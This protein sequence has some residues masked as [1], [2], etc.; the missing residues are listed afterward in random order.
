Q[1]NE[2]LEERT[3]ELEK[4]KDDIKQKNQDLE[5]SKS[6]LKTK[7]DDLELTSKYKSEFLAN[8]SHELR[9]P[10]NSILILSKIL[11]DNKTGNFTDKQVELADTINAAG[12]DLLTLINDI[13]DLSKIEAGKM[14]LHVETV[15]LGDF[16]EDVNRKFKPATDEKGIAFK[17]D[18]AKELPVSILTDRQRLDQIIKNFLSNAIKFTEKGS[19]TLSICRPQTGLD[20]PSGNFESD[21]IVAISVIDTGIGIPKDKQSMIFEAFQQVDGTTS[22]K[23]GGT[24][25]GLSICRELVR[26]LGGKIE[27]Q[28]EMGKGSSFTVYLPEAFKEEQKT[29]DNNKLAVGNVQLANNE[30]VSESVAQSATSNEQP[31]TSNQFKPSDLESDLVW[32][33]RRN[34][35]LGDK[36][37]LVIEDDSKFAKII[38]ELAHEKGF[39]CLVAENGEIGLYMADYYKPSAIILDIGLPGIDGFSVMERLKS[40]PAT[41]HIPVNFLSGS[42]RSIDAMKMGAVGFLTKPATIEMLNGLFGKF[43]NIIAKK[44]KK[45][46]IVEDN[47]SMRKSIIELLGNGDITSTGVSTGEEAYELLKTG[48][49]DCMVLDL[50]LS[51]MSGS[52]LLD[53]I[54][55]NKAIS[56]IP[57]IIYTGKELP[58]REES[59]LKKYA[60][61][62]IIKG[63]KSPERLLDETALFLHRVEANLPIEKQRILRTIHNKDAVF[64][65]KKILLIDDDMRNVFALTH[66]IEEKGMEVVIGRNGRDGL[67]CLNK[68]PDVDLVL[69]D[70]MMPEMDGY[71]ATREI[72]KQVRFK[73]LP[74]IA[75][76]AKAMA[77]DKNKCVEAGAND[78]LP[79]PIDTDKLLSLLRVWLYK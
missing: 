10:L 76:T 51:D 25:L 17:I 30:Q 60:D 69:M 21:K 12:G 78:Y 61:S 73:N 5:E 34:Y 32:D 24:G 47:E 65:N 27:L 44:V 37:I 68:N 49:F 11:A 57:V 28:S 55:S 39:K 75:I 14:T 52:D 36:S 45:L 71:E 3:E 19:V 56:Y 66:V 46:L 15:S 29:E 50:G 13:L 79:K 16:A 58:E 41:R 54:R 8:M 74:I 40:N 42:E 2:E 20:L 4:Q 67:E 23:F 33:D 53:K 64:E 31:V 6:E 1:T 59:I 38:F 43:E 22:R 48:E 18:L 35:K 70:I 62:V 7:A 9:T 63:A 72:R 77:G 26:L